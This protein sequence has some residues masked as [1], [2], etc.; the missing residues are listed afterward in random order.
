[1]D[2]VAAVCAAGLQAGGLDDTGSHR[3]FL[4]GKITR[5]MTSALT[6]PS[7]ATAANLGDGAW[8]IRHPASNSQ[9]R[10]RLPFHASTAFLK[11]RVASP[12]PRLGCHDITFP[13]A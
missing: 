6:I 12:G 1:M 4:P 5:A 13:N 10:A 3:A 2:S 9:A 8:A 7:A 11:R